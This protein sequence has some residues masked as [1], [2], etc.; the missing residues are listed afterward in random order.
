M[1]ASFTLFLVDLVT[2]P[3]LLAA[4]SEADARARLFAEDPQTD[5]AEPASDDAVRAL[6]GNDLTDDELELMRQGNFNRLFRHLRDNPRPTTSG[7][8][9]GT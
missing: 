3:E 2:D 6:F 7:D 4:Y 9:I 1:S 8:R 5:P